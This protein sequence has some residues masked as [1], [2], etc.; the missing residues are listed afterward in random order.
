VLL[1]AAVSEGFCNAVVEAQAMALPVIC[2]DADGLLENIVDGTT[3]FLAPRRDVHALADKLLLLAH[4]PALRQQLGQAGAERVRANFRLED[5]MAAFE[6][7][8]NCTLSGLNKA[9]DACLAQDSA[10]SNA[11]SAQHVYGLANDEHAS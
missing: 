8:Y 2:T 7:L 10:E 9:G 5:Q 1:H 4:D 3:G 11:Q 6:Q